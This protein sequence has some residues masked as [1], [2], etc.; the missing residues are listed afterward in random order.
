MNEMK[1]QSLD[2]YMNCIPVHPLNTIVALIAFYSSHVFEL[3][4]CFIVALL[5]KANGERFIHDTVGWF[6]ESVFEICPEQLL[7]DVALLRPFDVRSSLH[8]NLESWRQI[9]VGDLFQKNQNETVTILFHESRLCHR[10]LKVTPRR[11][12][13]GV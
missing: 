12:G 5:E 8:L 10:Q 9:T 13:E 11:Q 1:C 6:S 7:T 2:N 3:I 4:H